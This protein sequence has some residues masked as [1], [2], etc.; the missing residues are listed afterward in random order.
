M[1]LY[2]FIMDNILHHINDH[3]N[4]IIYTLFINTLF[5]INNINI[6]SFTHITTPLSVDDTTLLAQH[7]CSQ[8]TILESTYSKSI[9]FIRLSD[10]T[11]LN[12]N[13]FIIS[14]LENIVNLH[15]KT[16]FLLICPS[17]NFNSKTCSPELLSIKILPFITNK[18]SAYYSVG[19]LC[20]NVLNMRLADLKNTRLFYFLTRCLNKIPHMRKCIFV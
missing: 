12:N 6:T 16:D 8:L 20:L 14:N 5:N 1:P 10:I 11:V 17:T 9:A 2:N 19:L 7:L 4:D 15:N 18:S 3:K 13:M